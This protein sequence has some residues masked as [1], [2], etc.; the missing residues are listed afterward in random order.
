MAKP[1][2]CCRHPLCHEIDEALFRGDSLRSVSTAY[3]VSR[4]SLSRHASHERRT[5]ANVTR[6]YSCVRYP[7]LRIGRGI[8]FRDGRFETADPGLQ[9]LVEGNSWFGVF[10]ERADAPN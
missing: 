2:S 3:S 7:E 5:R 6:T 4:S 8:V 1:C 9:A 10:I